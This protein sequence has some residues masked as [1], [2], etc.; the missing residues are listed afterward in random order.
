MDFQ[1]YIKKRKKI[2]KFFKNSVDNLRMRVYTSAHRRDERRLI[3][4]VSADVID[5]K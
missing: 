3:G 1:W 2:E 4:A 5:K